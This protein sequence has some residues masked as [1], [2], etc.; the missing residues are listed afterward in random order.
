MALVQDAYFINRQ[1]RTNEPRPAA[2]GTAIHTGIA[3]LFGAL[4]LMIP[5][6]AI[7]GLALLGGVYLVAAALLA[8]AAL[9]KARRVPVSW[10]RLV[11]DEVAD[12]AQG[13]A[14]VWP[15]VAVI[16]FVVVLGA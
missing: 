6:V 10:D 11:Q 15:I 3:A 5:G 1:D 12:L 7:A 16:A 13:D 9:V 4:A 8:G 14:A 2:V